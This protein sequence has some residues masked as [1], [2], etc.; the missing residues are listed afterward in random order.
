MRAIVEAQGVR[1]VEDAAH[2]VWAIAQSTGTYRRS[3][4][5]HPSW[6]TCSA[7]SSTGTRAR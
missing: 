6:R 3:R 4:L 7:L 1:V 5:W 2:D